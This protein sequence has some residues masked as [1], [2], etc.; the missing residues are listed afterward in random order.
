MH[1]KSDDWLI[2]KVSLDHVNYAKSAY[3]FNT[4]EVQENYFPH[5]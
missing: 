5:D 2:T 1:T 4:F 3:L